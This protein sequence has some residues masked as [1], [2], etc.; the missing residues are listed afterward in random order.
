[1]S[2]RA[3]A[4]YLPQF[5]PIPENDEWWG[6]GFTEWRKVTAARPIYEKHCQPRVPVDLGYYDLRL[7]EV[8]EEQARLAASYG[9]YGFCYYYYWFGGKKLLNAPI[10]AVSASGEPNFP[11][12]CAGQTR[13]G[14]VGGMASTKTC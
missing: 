2:V 11:F 8:R 12:V 4:F 14:P 1:M 9:I 5:H 6:K 10:E 13:I 3:I 7:K